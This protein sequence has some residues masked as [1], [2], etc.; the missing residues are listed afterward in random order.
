MKKVIIFLSIATLPLYTTAYIISKLL[1]IKGVEDMTT[2]KEWI[3]LYKEYE[4]E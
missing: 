4:K 2:L 3:F 1:K